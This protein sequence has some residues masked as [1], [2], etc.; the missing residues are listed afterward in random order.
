MGFPPLRPNAKFLKFFIPQFRPNCE[1]GD[2]DLAHL[3]VFNNARYPAITSKLASCVQAV[4]LCHAK[5]I[6]PIFPQRP[7]QF[8]LIPKVMQVRYGLAHGKRGLVQVHRAGK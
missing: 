3:P 8:P 7:Y 5:A 6:N 2:P 1:D 4:Q